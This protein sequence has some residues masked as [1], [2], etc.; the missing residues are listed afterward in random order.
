MLTWPVNDDGEKNGRAN[1]FT[2]TFMAYRNPR[3][4]R[5]H[6]SEELLAEFLLLN[7]L[8]RLEFEAVAVS[9]VKDKASL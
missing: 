2:G 1:L 7:Q 5:E 9:A 4:H 8:Y 6:S 3:A